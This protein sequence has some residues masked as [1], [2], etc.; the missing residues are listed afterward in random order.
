MISRIPC[1]LPSFLADSAIFSHW[2]ALWN[3]Y[4]RGS[5][6]PCGLTLRSLAHWLFS[7]KST[8]LNRRPSQSGPNPSPSSYP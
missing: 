4:H 6:G 7:K 8:L 5:L 1:P 2:H 3:Q